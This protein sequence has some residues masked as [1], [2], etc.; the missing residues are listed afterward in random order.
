MKKIYLSLALIAAAT[1]SLQAE[2]VLVGVQSYTVV[3]AEDGTETLNKGYITIEHYYNAQLQNHV[4]FSNGFITKKYDEQGRLTTET[5]YN[6]YGGAFQKQV[7][8]EYDEAGNLVKATSE[9]TTYTSVVEY[10]NFQNGVATHTKTT[11]N[12][13]VKE[14][15]ILMTFTEAGLLARSVSNNTV[16]A[17][18]YNEA[19]Q[20][21]L[22]ESEWIADATLESVFDPT[23]SDYSKK[24]YTYNED[25]TLKAIRTINTYS[26][27]E[28]QYTYADV[29]GEWAPQNVA[30]T[31]AAGNIVTVT[32]DAVEGAEGYVVTYPKTDN[33]IFADTVKTNE[34]VTASLI[35]GN[36]YFLVR[37]IIGGEVKAAAS[38]RKYLEV[39]DN[40]KV[41][42]TDFA[43]VS[44]SYEE[45]PNSWGGTDQN[46]VSVFTW[47]EADPSLVTGRKL[48]YGEASYQQVDL[49]DVEVAA[50]GTCTGKAN[51]SIWNAL[52]PDE[53][54]NYTI[55][56][57]LTLAV[58]LQYATGAA[59]KSNAV[60]VNI[61]EESEKPTVAI[62]E[63]REAAEAAAYTLDGQLCK[64]TLTKGFYVVGG[65]KIVVR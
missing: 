38:N 61:K 28:E 48:S 16:T 13:V 52:D 20:T 56:K 24:V 31:A 29:K 32:W 21:T 3:T 62:A 47:K 58:I 65:K 2:N 15:D 40:T 26:T 11:Q 64:G 12:D 35:D 42:A 22:V 17:Y 1:L 7:R 39:K 30:A 37:P 36:Y 23:S 60:V 10:S 27:I 44:T 57:E 5:T 46:Y 53:N 43:F 50:D 41:A 18:T 51:L 9:M 33:G 14:E 45:T 25:G 19:G 63:I 34:L 54:W 49:Y 6:N 59:D 8:N 4:S 55:A